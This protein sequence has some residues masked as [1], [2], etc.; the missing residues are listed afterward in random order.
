MDY[1][2]ATLADIDFEHERKLEKAKQSAMEASLTAGVVAKLEQRHQEPSQPY[3]QEL[4]TL[5]TAQGSALMW[6]QTSRWTRA[7]A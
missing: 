2:L 6:R 1:L 4:V 5:Q 7:S 3:V